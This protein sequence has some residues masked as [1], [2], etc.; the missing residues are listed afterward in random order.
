MVNKFTAKILNAIKESGIPDDAEKVIRF[1]GRD[2]PV[3]NE[4]MENA[5]RKY[6]IYLVS[7]NIN[8]FDKEEKYI[9]KAD[10]KI[11]FSQFLF[12]RK[13]LLETP[14]PRTKITDYI[15]GDNNFDDMLNKMNE[16]DE[17]MKGYREKNIKKY[18]P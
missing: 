4:V 1:L 11:S 7:F 18:K 13:H 5:L 10:Q 8:T 16:I 6:K 3:T 2:G 14:L 9:S 15:F 17:K 12:E